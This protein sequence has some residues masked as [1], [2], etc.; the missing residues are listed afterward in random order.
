[1]EPMVCVIALDIEH[2]PGQI[3]QPFQHMEKRDLI[4]NFKIIYLNIIRLQI[5]PIA[6]N[7]F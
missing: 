1:M 4:Q 2:G 5:C 6:P 7:F 3:F